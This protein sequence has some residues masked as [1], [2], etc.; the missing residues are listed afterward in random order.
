MIHAA[1]D[2]GRSGGFAIVAPGL[3]LAWKM[4]DYL[5]DFCTKLAIAEVEIL[6]HVNDVNADIYAYLELVHAM[7]NDAKGTIFAFGRNFGQCEF[8]MTLAF[9][10]PELVAPQVWQR[11]FGITTIKFA[12]KTEKKNYHKKLAQE[13]FPE[14]K[15]THAI[16]DALLIAE[17]GRRSQ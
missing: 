5:P 3:A 9:G 15:V 17:H 13:L 1:C 8:A 4:P 12:S 10:D 2:P 14:L 7:P 16:A 6:D 11:T